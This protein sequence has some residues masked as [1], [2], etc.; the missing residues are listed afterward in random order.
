M[1]TMLNPLQTGFFSPTYTLF[2]MPH[3]LCRLYRMVGLENIRPKGYDAHELS[4]H[5][6]A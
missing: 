3:S 1:V 5:R 4:K 6:K 2:P